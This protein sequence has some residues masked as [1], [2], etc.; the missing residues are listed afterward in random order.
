MT[1]GD[2]NGQPRKFLQQPDRGEVNGVKTY[3]N[4]E[5]EDQTNSNGGIAIRLQQVSLDNEE[6]HTVIVEQLGDKGSNSNGN[7]RTVKDSGSASK[8]DYVKR[9]MQSKQ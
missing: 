4:S 8:K 1:K 7:A 5:G 9:G 3:N 6:Q 2:A